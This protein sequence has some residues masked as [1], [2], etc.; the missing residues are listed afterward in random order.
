VQCSGMSVIRDE[1]GEAI[2]DYITRDPLLKPCEGH[3]VRGHDKCI[4][5]CTKLE[6][7][8]MSQATW[9]ARHEKEVNELMWSLDIEMHPMDGLLE[10]VQMCGTMARMFQ[11]LVSELPEEPY[12]DMIVGPGG[13]PVAGDTHVGLWGYDHNRD[14]SPHV[15]LNLMQVWTDR[16]MRACKMALDAGIDERI[17]RNAE[18]TSG[19]FLTAFER[20]LRSMPLSEDVRQSL[21]EAMAREVRQGIA[22][23]SNPQLEEAAR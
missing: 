4:V 3:A 9:M 14:Q 18:S 5:H 17:V 8:K 16:Y 1:N 2:R 11:L 7:Q 10:A 19:I 22:R 23:T 12:T 21:S 13:T 20:A 15:L 6:R